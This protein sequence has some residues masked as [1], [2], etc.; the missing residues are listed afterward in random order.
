MKD[1]SL[2]V[3]RSFMWKKPLHC[4]NIDGTD[5]VFYWVALKR[6]NL[7]ETAVN[8]LIQTLILSLHGVL[9]HFMQFNALEMSGGYYCL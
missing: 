5:L 6:E 3:P 9:S 1:E 7:R 2:T 4:S 8:K